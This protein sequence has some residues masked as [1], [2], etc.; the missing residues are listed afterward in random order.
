MRPRNLPEHPIPDTACRLNCRIIAAAPAGIP[1]LRGPSPRPVI[2]LPISPGPRT[3]WVPAVTIALALASTIV[4]VV[5]MHD[6]DALKSAAVFYVDSGLAAIELPRYRD[7]LQQSNESDAVARLAQLEHAVGPSLGRPSDPLATIDLLHEDREFERGLRTGAIIAPSD[8]VY[9]DWRRDRQRFDQLGNAAQAHHL[10]LSGQV[11][12]E[13]WRLITYQ[14][15]HPTAASWLVNLCVLL[16]IGPFAEAAAGAGIFLLCYLGGGACAGIAHLFVS[17]QPA[18]GDWG[19]LTALAAMLA[20]ALGLHS[21]RARLILM[22]H[23]VLV[24]GLAALLVVAGVEALRWAVAG[25]SAVDVPTDLSGLA[26]GAALATLLKLRHSRRMRALTA[27]AQSADDHSLKES[28][29][30]VQAREAATRQDSR[31]AKELFKELV[32]LEPDRIEHL[33]AYLN[34]ALLGA[35][36]TTLQDAALRLLWLRSRSHSEQFRK[37]FLQLT[38]PKVLKVLPIDEHLRLARRLVRLREDAAALRVLD[39]ILQDDHLRELY[40]RQLA[41]CLLGIYTG[42]MRRRLTTLAE[43]I[44]SRLTTYFESSSGKLGGLPPAKSP[45]TT[46]FT[47]APRSRLPPRP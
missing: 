1:G 11:W 15:V 4:F 8:P 35:D 34:V 47:S 36:E 10:T 22:P 2:A 5:C 38:Q 33:C 37:A 13:P 20:A 6:R 19:A 39:G 16:L 44:R 43:T 3:R 32:E 29:L 24:P 23:R 28:A 25:R 9:P 46:L 30:A 31:R 21:I 12:S 45:P 26:F 40:G 17:S 14:F 18:V 27:H 41:D 7:Y 42:Y